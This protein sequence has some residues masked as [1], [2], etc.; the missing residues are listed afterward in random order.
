MLF[1]LATT[2]LYP[3]LDVS[4][5]KPSLVMG[6]ARLLLFAMNLDLCFGNAKNPVA[7]ENLQLLTI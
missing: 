5:L 1:A 6:N 4:G 2:A 3:W 7:K